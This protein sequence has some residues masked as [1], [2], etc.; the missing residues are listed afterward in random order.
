MSVHRSLKVAV[1]VDISNQLAHYRA[2]VLALIVL[3]ILDDSLAV[4][5]QTFDLQYQTALVIFYLDLGVDAQQ[6]SA[7]GV[8]FG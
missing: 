6:Y 2:A 5:V 1:I 4:F 3:H 8:A 7:D